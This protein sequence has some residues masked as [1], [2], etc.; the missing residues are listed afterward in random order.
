MEGGGRYRYPVAEGYKRSGFVIAKRGGYVRVRERL[1][2][3]VLR[4]LC[5]LFRRDAGVGWG[6]VDV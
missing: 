2:F 6:L 1:G 5:F 4:P 3:Y